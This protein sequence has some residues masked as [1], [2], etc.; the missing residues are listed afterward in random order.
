LIDGR[1]QAEVDSRLG[2]LQGHAGMI[3][4]APFRCRVASRCRLV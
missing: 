1:R 3:T 2:L 4:A